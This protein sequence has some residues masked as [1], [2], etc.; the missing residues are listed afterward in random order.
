MSNGFSNYS[1]VLAIVNDFN[2]NFTLDG[3]SLD[4]NQIATYDEQ[5][6]SW[7]LTQR[8]ISI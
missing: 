7:V 2:K 3:F 5:L 4:A 6:H 1:D 8:G